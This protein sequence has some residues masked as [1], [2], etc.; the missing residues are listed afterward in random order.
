ML[1]IYGDRAPDELIRKMNSRKDKYDI[2][3]KVHISVG[4]KEIYKMMHDYEAV[5]I[6]DLPSQLRNRCYFVGNRKDSFV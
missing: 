5:I 6:W 4:D 1:V 3:G 2:S